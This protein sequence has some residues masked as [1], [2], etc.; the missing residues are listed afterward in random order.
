MGKKGTNYPFMAGLIAYL[1]YI[2]VNW[3]VKMMAG[4]GGWLL[5]G[6]HRLVYLAYHTLGRDFRLLARG[7]PIVFS[8]LKVKRQGL[9]VPKMFR[10]N[11]VDRADRVMFFDENK[12]L[13]YR[14]AEELSNQVANYFLNLKYNKGDTVALFMENRIEYIPIW[15]GMAKVGVVPALINSNLKQNSLVHCI[16]AA[17]CRALVCSRDLLPVVREV[18]ADLENTDG[19][20]RVFCYDEHLGKQQANCTDF[21]KELEQCSRAP[22]PVAVADS[23]GFNDPLLYIYTSGT[24]GLPKAV[25][26]KHFRQLFVMVAAFKAIGLSREDVIYCY[27]PLYHSSG[28]QIAT[29]SA[30]LFGTK[31]FIKRKFSASAFWKDCVKHNITATQ[32]IGE[33]CRYLLASPSIPEEKL[34]KVTRMFGNGLRPQVWEEFVT[35]FNISNI[36]EFYGATEGNSNMVNNENRVGAVGFVGVIEPAWLQEL[37]LPLLLVKLDPETGEPC[38]DSQGFCIPCEPGE[39]GEMVGKIVK[40]DPLK[41][42]NGYR[43]RSA[44]QKKIMCDVKRQGDRY[45]RSGDILVMDEF[46]WVYFK[47]RAGDTFRW[48]GENVSTAEVEVTVSRLLEGRG[49][50]AYGVQVGETEG[51]AG[52]VCVQGRREEVDLETLLTG[53]TNQLPAY[54]RP[55]FYRFS[56]DLDMTGTYKLKKVSLQSEGIDVA[57]VSDPIFFVDP[58]TNKVQTLDAE[59]YAALQS[60]QI[61]V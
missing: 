61:K 10:R 35:R 19:G 43:D 55:L 30:I 24:T 23:I 27:L 20:F 42:F 15:L 8:L 49:V 59:L 41:E 33:I 48:K 56:G 9:T 46:G 44:T 50:V 14:D 36:S 7:L 29:A 1:A 6:G 47:D 5:T 17:G 39:P 34:H 45:F 31:T 4:L 53:L 25:V 21:R 51:R 13:T 57:Q 18:Q 28:G 58:R 11:L 38:R 26:I 12:S 2:N 22:E 40:G 37:L 60:G 3:K 52:M 16:R 54:A 32:Y